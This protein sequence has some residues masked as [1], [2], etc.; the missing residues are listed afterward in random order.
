MLMR[1]YSHYVRDPQG[2]ELEQSQDLSGKDIQRIGA[3]TNLFE[4]SN[5]FRYSN[6]LPSYRTTTRTRARF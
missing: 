1:Q 3:W 2:I 5:F 6:L 4:A